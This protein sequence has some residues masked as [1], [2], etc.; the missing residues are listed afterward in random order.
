M[1]DNEPYI[2]GNM[3]G[4]YHSLCTLKTSIV[5]FRKEKEFCSL[6]KSQYF[7]F[8][9]KSPHMPSSPLWP[10]IGQTIYYKSLTIFVTYTLY[11]VYLDIARIELA[12]FTVV[13]CT[14]WQ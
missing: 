13:V 9:G 1:P 11:R 10:F 3:F 5:D 6:Y 7:W 12:A 4:E 8:L 2:I 14:D